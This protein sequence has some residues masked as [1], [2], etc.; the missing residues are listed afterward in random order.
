VA[1]LLQS[2]EYSRKDHRLMFSLAAIQFVLTVRDLRKLRLR[3]SIGMLAS[4]SHSSPL[5]WVVPHC[6]ALCQRQFPLPS[7]VR[8]RLVG[9]APNLLGSEPRQVPRDGKWL[10]RKDPI[11]GHHECG[12]ACMS[13]YTTSSCSCS[14]SSLPAASVSVR[15]CWR[16]W[17]GLA[18]HL[19]SA[20]SSLLVPSARRRWG[21]GSRA[22]TAA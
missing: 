13:M 5:G 2:G 14:G 19:R 4:L 1:F 21:F 16:I 17:I 6:P 10:A 22:M 8:Y 11:H 12:R 15:P 18:R 9:R 3:G 7:D 20:L